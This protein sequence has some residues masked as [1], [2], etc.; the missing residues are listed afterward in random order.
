MLIVFLN[1]FAVNQ[2]IHLAKRAFRPFQ[3]LWDPLL[4]VF[5]GWSDPKWWAVEAEPAKCCD[6]GRSLDDPGDRRNSHQACWTQLLWQVWLAYGRHWVRGAVPSRYFHSALLDP[7]RCVCCCWTKVLQVYNHASTPLC[8]FVNFTFV[9]SGKALFFCF[10]KE[11][12]WDS[13][14]CTKGIRFRFQL[15]FYNAI[16]TVQSAKSWK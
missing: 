9:P 7:H 8:R 6:K 11:R 3:D 2:D 10:W 14:W 1:R 4:E 16:R 13:P 12:D 5:W 15:K